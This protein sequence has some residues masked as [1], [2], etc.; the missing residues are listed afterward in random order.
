MKN[1]FVSNLGFRITSEDLKSV[2]EE[3]GE[4]VSAKVITD[5]I[6]GRSRGFGFVEMQND[7]EALNAIQKLN[8]AELEGRALSV[9][10]ARPRGERRPDSGARSGGYDHQRNSRY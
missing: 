9:S 6:S 8:D 2:F 5:N 4:V 10:E 7:E 1:L 3:Y